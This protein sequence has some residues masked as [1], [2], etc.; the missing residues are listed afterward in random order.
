MVV[1]RT[2]AGRLTWTPSMLEEPRSQGRELDG[3]G[4]YPD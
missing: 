3:E 2:D 1:G 4:Y